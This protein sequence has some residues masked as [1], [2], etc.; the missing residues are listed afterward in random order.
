MLHEKDVRRALLH[1]TALGDT[2]IFPTPF[3]YH[4]YREN[5]DKIVDDSKKVDFGRYR[6]RG[7]IELLS[8]KGAYSFRIAHQLYPADT[9][10]YT[11]AVLEIAGDIERLRQP[12][13]KGPFS[14]RFVDDEGEARVFAS[15]SSFHDWIEHLKSVYEKNN[16]K[17]VVVMESD[18]SDFYSRIYFHRIEHVLDDVNA[19]NP[20]RKIIE[21]IIKF[22]RGRQSHGLPV[23]ST[24]SR[25]LAEGLLNDT[26]VTMTEDVVAYSRYVDDFRMVCKSEPDGHSTVCKL[27]EHLMLTEGLSL[28]SSKTKM[29]SVPSA[30]KDCEHKLSDVLNDE[31]I[32]EVSQYIRR[33]YEAE[34]VSVDDIDDVDPEKIVDRVREIM[35]RDTVDYGA[36][37]V[38]LRA[39]RATGY[40]K[41]DEF[42][43]EFPGLLYFLPRDF[44][45]LA[46][47]LAQRHV[48]KAE[49][50]AAVLVKT[51][52]EAPAKEIVLAKVW[53]A[54]LFVSGA[55]PVTRPLLSS[56]SL[57]SSALEQRANFLIRGRLRDRA[58]FRA[59]KTGFNETSDWVK[60]ALLFGASC[61]SR[62]EY[63]TWLD[64][65]SDHYDDPFA[66]TYLK[67]LKTNQN[68]LFDKISEDFKVQSRAERIGAEFAKLFDDVDDDDEPFA[69]EGV[70]APKS[71]AA[72]LDDEL[73]AKP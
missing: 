51:C 30:V 15:A 43:A 47:A 23:G 60:S 36:L 24:A 1:L 8:P 17:N 66:A 68:D 46:G 9:V 65:V 27:A 14:Y 69:V 41:A 34:D 73:L 31:D 6:P 32:V 52:N 61:M 35:N 49:K 67:W 44:S 70:A 3:E 38:L 53:V 5:A 50:I 33:V 12:I 18:I 13:E 45:L 42:V 19:R 64:T 7:A 40:D 56:L 25:I 22:S 26:D 71:A 29:L 2:D 62:S 57:G 54:H 20:V 16:K 37:K 72:E 10:L 21:G 63:R 28:N 11:A 48:D 58:Y 39:L 4:F 55:L 59:R